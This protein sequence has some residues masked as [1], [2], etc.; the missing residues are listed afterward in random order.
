MH[1]FT[2]TNRQQYWLLKC[3]AMIRPGMHHDITTYWQTVFHLLASV[4][5][6]MLDCIH[7]CVSSVCRQW[8][9]SELG[10]PQSVGMATLRLTR[11]QCQPERGKLAF[12][13]ESLIAGSPHIVGNAVFATLNTE[14]CILLVLG[15]LT[16]YYYYLNRYSVLLLKSTLFVFANLMLLYLFCSYSSTF[17]IK[18][19]I[20]LLLS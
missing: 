3:A 19:C 17:E 12:H 16:R 10:I 6:H 18:V 14:G 15:T 13:R 20:T 5:V 11:Q 8:P 2:T 4:L 7:P 9:G 1:C